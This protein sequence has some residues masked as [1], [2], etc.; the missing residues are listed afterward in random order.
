MNTVPT[1]RPQIAGSA[2]FEVGDQRI[3]VR[4]APASVG[5]AHS[6]ELKSQ[7]GHLRMHQG[8]CT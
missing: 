5:L 8:T 7:Y 6:C 3:D 2:M 4:V 1:L